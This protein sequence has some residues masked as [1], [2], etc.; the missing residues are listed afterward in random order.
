MKKFYFIIFLLLFIFKYLSAQ[1]ISN[2]IFNPY[3]DLTIEED[4]YL[5][6]EKV[7]EKKWFDFGGYFRIRNNLFHNFDLNRG[8]TPT[9]K[10]PIWQ[11]SPIKGEDIQRSSNMRLR[12]CPEIN[13]GYEIKI[14]SQIDFLDNIILGS[15]PKGFPRTDE[16]PEISISTSQDVPSAGR[17]SFKDSISVKKIWAEMQTPFGLFLAGRMPMNWGLG[18]VA[19]SGNRIDDDYDESVD[20]IGFVTTFFDHLIGISFDFNTNG[21]SSASSLNPDGQPYDL[22]DYDDINTI[23]FGFLKYFTPEI[24]K[25]KLN[26]GKVVFNYG[27]FISYRWQEGEAPSYYILGIEGED[28]NYKES[29]FVK[30]DAY[31]LLSDIWLRLNIKYFRFEFEGA[32]IH[33]RVANA[34]MMPNIKMPPIAFDQFGFSA[35]TQWQ[36]L[37]KIP[38]SLLGEIGVASGDKAYG[39]GVSPPLS[40]NTSKPGDIDGPQFKIGDD[41]EVNNFKF[42]PNYHID[43][44]LWRRIVGAF[45]DGIYFKSG[46]KYYP[47]SSLKFDLNF[48]YSRVLYAES[49]PGL[50]KPLGF[51]IDGNITYFSKDGFEAIFKYGVLFPLAGFRNVF[52]NLQPK[53]A[54]FLSLILA[55]RF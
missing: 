42:N 53:P 29:E 6:Y 50:A 1:E 26:A 39:F 30:R 52:E 46:F 14:K 48:I 10:T 38:L 36:I 40:Q 22:T 51:E 27:A 18:I 2:P 17:N 24:L 13:I 28:R 33:G 19:N 32:Y 4:R 49:A 21:P 44:I 23:S 31:F 11:L 54:Q 16:I 25:I 5:E 12:F 45:T 9:L 35:Q 7:F 20:R 43:E 41:M 55:Y 37:K 8:S 15:T 47:F 3:K 34:S